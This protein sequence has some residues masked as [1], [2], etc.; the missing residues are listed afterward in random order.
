MS[1]GKIGLNYINMVNIKPKDYINKMIGPN[2]S[3]TVDNSYTNT[4]F[5]NV[6]QNNSYKID[7]QVFH[8]QDAARR[9]SYQA[10]AKWDKAATTNKIRVASEQVVD[11][12]KVNQQGM[13][14]AIDVPYVKSTYDDI[15]PA[16]TASH[17]KK[18]VNL[19]VVG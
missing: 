16:Y 4:G 13:R 12:N 9:E 17:L 14:K 6:S 3:V 10:Y 5:R 1:A 11:V 7:R 18:G 8:R 19:N 2:N 15:M